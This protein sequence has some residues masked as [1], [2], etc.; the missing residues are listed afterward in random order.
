MKRKRAMLLLHGTL[1]ALF[2]LGCRELGRIQSTSREA[3]R[4]ARLAVVGRTP[5]GQLQLALSNQ[6]TE[7][8]AYVGYRETGNPVVGVTV[9][10]RKEG[11]FD[12]A[13]GWCWTGTEALPL[14]PGSVVRFSV[15]VP[16]SLS[17]PTRFGVSISTR[18]AVG[19]DVLDA[20][21]PWWTVLSQP[22]WSEGAGG[23]GRAHR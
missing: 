1:F 23:Y 10:T 21:Q 14:P 16:T 22:V 12:T 17:R 5:D 2:G 19:R 15:G 13:A 9:F 4:D 11:W 6:G 3:D 18:E 20:P 7:E 8:L